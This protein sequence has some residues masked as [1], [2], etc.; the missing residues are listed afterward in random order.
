[1]SLWI[2]CFA[3]TSVS[4]TLIF[5]GLGVVSCHTDDLC[6][7]WVKVTTE[8]EK[9]ARVPL[10]GFAPWRNELSRGGWRY[11]PRNERES[12]TL[13][14]IWWSEEET[15]TGDIKRLHTLDAGFLW[16]KK[17]RLI[18]IIS[19]CFPSIIVSYSLYRSIEKK[20]VLWGGA[21][22]NRDDV[23]AEVCTRS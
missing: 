11:S 20:K 10:G 6:V 22:L 18:S 1:M 8:A 19:K 5:D 12:Q 2:W 21:K 3:F 15:M 13:L 17:M 7:W 4:G 14:E 23:V 9:S 16:Y